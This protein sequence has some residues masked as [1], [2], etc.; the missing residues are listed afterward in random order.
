MKN[1]KIIISVICAAV[2]FVGLCAAVYIPVVTNNLSVERRVSIFLE[3]YETAALEYV[4]SNEEAITRCGKEAL[5]ECTV[6][7]VVYRYA[8]DQYKSVLFISKAPE[9]AEEFND[10]IDYIEVSV[11][12]KKRESCAVRFEKDASGNMIIVGHE[13]E[14]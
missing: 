4:T 12:I 5:S 11:R 6:G 7:S 2:L 8:T 3:P 10:H 9:T 14:D 13:W 1:K